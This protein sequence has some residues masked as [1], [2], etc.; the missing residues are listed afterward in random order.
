MERQAWRTERAQTRGR[1]CCLCCSMPCALRHAV[2]L[3]HTMDGQQT[4]TTWWSEN[5]M[6]WWLSPHRHAPTH[7]MQ[8]K[9]DK[10]LQTAVVSLVHVSSGKRVRR[11]MNSG[12]I[13]NM[14]SMQAAWA[15]GWRQNQSSSDSESVRCVC[16]LNVVF[17]SHLCTEFWLTAHTITMLPV[18]NCSTQQW[19]DPSLCF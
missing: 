14:L 18:M 6:H 2:E 13:T 16:H 11:K 9:L 4:E 12:F 15:K 5:K 1:S 10:T 7:L 8:L 17:W 19:K 3:K